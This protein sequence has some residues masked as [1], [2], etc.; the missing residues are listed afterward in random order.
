M[1]WIYQLYFKIQYK[2][3]DMGDFQSKTTFDKIGLDT[4]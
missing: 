3:Q 2:T 1:H 4:F